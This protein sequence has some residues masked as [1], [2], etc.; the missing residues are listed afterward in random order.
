MEEFFEGADVARKRLVT[1]GTIRKD[2]DA[3]RLRI[4]ARTARGGRLYLQ[5]DVDEY[6]LECETRRKAQGRRS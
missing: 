3:G 5:E 4:A 6:L 2:A 1:P